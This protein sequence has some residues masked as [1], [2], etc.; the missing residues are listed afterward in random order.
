M[1]DAQPASIPIAASDAA[2][3]TGQWVTITGTVASTADGRLSID[4]AS[5]EPIDEP[6]GP[7]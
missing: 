1:I 2:L 5:V 7:V 6:D 3:E 4:A